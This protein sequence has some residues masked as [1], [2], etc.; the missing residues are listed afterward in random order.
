MSQNYR[1]AAATID[2]TQK[3]SLFEVPTRVAAARQ[4]NS[5]TE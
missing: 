5:T 2:P 3:S 4:L 1:R